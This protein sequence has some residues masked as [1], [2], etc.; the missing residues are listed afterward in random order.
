MYASLTHP[1]RKFNVLNYIYFVTLFLSFHSYFIGYINSS[2][3]SQYIDKSLVGLIYALGSIVNILILLKISNLFEKFGNYKTMLCIASI[4]L[5]TLIVL[6]TSQNPLLIIGTFILRNATGSILLLSLDN[7]LESASSKEKTGY[8]RGVF[9][10]LV[11]LTAAVSPVIVG[12]MLTES[13]YQSIYLF[14]ALFMIPLIIIVA[15]RFKRLKD[16]EYHHVHLGGGIKTM[17]EDKDLKNIYGANVLLQIFY[18][19]MVIY[20]PIYLHQV[21]GFSWQELGLMIS[22]ALIPFII[23]EIPVGTLADKKTGEKEILIL[24]FVVLI[25][26]LFGMSFIS[27]KSFIVWTLVLFLS[28]VGASLVEITSESYFFKKIN[29]SNENLISIFRTAWPVGLVMGPIIG[30]LFLLTL[31]QRYSFALLGIVMFLGIKFGLAIKDT[32]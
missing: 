30:S 14:S 29:L 25:I 15:K 31:D 28:R 21:I 8:V 27:G 13:S 6:A 24:G 32:K 20:V 2:F 12:S 11:S 16:N 22:F 3:L 18:S 9:N 23:L 1:K 5:L 10:T 4:D 17:L 7:F 19:W 26:S